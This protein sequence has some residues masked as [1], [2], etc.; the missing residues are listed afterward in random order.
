MRVYSRLSYIAIFLYFTG[1]V[2][3]YK[4]GLMFDGI[5]RKWHPVTWILFFIFFTPS[6]IYDKSILDY[7]PLELPDFWKNNLN[8]LQWVTPFTKLKDI[9]QFN[10]NEM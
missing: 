8:Q 9:K 6:V 3:L 10:V 7:L 1:C 2:R 4:D 5:F